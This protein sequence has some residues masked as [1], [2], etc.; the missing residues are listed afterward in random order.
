[1][2]PDNKLV[3]S[4]ELPANT[5]PSS[6]IFLEPTVEVSGRAPAGVPELEAQIEACEEVI[7]SGEIAIKRQAETIAMLTDQNAQFRRAVQDARGEIE[8]RDSWEISPWAYGIG[9]AL[10]GGYLTH[11]LSK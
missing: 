4:I 7:E 3:P 2:I 5:Q 9:G 1:M 6:P 10:I 8:K 11:K